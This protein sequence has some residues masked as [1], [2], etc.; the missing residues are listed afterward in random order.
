MVSWATEAEAAGGS[1]EAGVTA[2]VFIAPALDVTQRCARYRGMK[3][4]R[5]P[6]RESF[7]Q[8]EALRSERGEV[9]GDRVS[10]AGVCLV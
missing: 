10:F 9:G 2:V 1:C 3:R 4:W 6:V 7:N 8:E 5:E